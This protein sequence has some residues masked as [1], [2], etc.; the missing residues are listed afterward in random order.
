MSYALN[1]LPPDTNLAYQSEGSDFGGAIHINAIMFASR[2][3][4]ATDSHGDNL[5][6]VAVQRNGEW[7]LQSVQVKW[8]D[9]NKQLVVRLNINPSDLI[10][11][12]RLYHAGNS[13]VFR[14]PESINAGL[15]VA[16]L[17]H[18]EE[19]S[20][21][22]PV[23]IQA[24]HE[25]A[26]EN[27]SFESDHSSGFLSGTNA[28]AGWQR[29]NLGGNMMIRNTYNSDWNGLHAKDGMNSLFISDGCMIG[30]TLSENFDNHTDYKLSVAV[31]EESGPLTFRNHEHLKL[32]LLAGTTVLG[33]SAITFS[34]YI[35]GEN[36]DGASVGWKTFEV[37]ISGG[38]HSILEG[39][40]MRIELID[41]QNQDEYD[42]NYNGN[43]FYLD[44]VHL[45]KL[46]QSMATFD[47]P[48]D[49]H[50]ASTTTP[51]NQNSTPML[52]S[53]VL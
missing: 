14:K 4:A 12:V 27:S 5:Y 19:V 8:P 11:G 43:G 9:D 49:V 30:Q 42:R 35:P 3:L 10:T 22:E 1:S 44:N 47:G 39:Q 23:N 13:T 52:T 40:P 31:S 32:R 24:Y 15:D 18:A 21:S 7:E 34:D 53:T 46:T 2:H 48:S 25:V 37:N 26:I 38:E 28:P 41:E 36:H 50:I 29:P 33:E 20:I 51:M 17:P 45:Q 16:S 6:Q